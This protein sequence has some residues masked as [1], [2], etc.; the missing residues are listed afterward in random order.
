[1]QLGMIGL[2]RMGANMVRRLLKAGHEGVVFDVS[3]KSVEELVHEKAVG[4]S[5]LA[6]LVKKLDKPRALW[7]MVPAAIVDK[8][9]AELGLLLEPGD[10]LIDGGNSYYVDD[11]RR[12]K[13]LAMKNI[14]Y[15]D[16]GTSG[17][18]WGLERG[19]C[20]MIG[21]EP[22]VVSHLDPIFAA[23]APGIGDISRTPGREKLGTTSELG[24]LHCGPNGAGHFVKMVHNGIEYGIMAAYAEGLGVLRSANIGKQESAIDAETTPL[25]D[26]EDY[27]YDLDLGN[28]AE[29]WRRGSVIASWLLDLTAISLAK[30][31][32]LSGFVGKVSD[33]GEGRWT[34][35]AA[36][37]EGVPVPVLTTAL[38]E[39]FS[40]RGD[41][42]FQDRL[43]SAMRFQF[44][45][46]VEKSA[47]K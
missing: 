33:S 1:M 39:R 43:L 47:K 7:L 22:A 45:G 44:G 29:V 32:A 30:D 26:P 35:K 10:I 18:I 31:P 46:H 13:E 41:A 27:Q 42:D 28:I 9:I 24:Y 3:P 6:D 21:G 34:I 20:M 14:H 11:I 16:V 5:S 15:V 17:G 37:D 19:Y 38:Y 40:S 36:I 4:A 23:L 2:G 8:T 25:R 12:A